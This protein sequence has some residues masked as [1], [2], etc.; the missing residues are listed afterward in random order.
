LRTFA[1]EKI[2]DY[3]CKEGLSATVPI[4]TFEYNHQG[5]H[6]TYTFTTPQVNISFNFSFFSFPF[7]FSKKIFFLKGI[8]DNCDVKRVN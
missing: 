7:N 1:I 4:F 8:G 6:T 5:I 2:K 3:G